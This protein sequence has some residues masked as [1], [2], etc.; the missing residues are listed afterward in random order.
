MQVR[1][2]DDAKLREEEYAN[3]HKFQAV[4]TLSL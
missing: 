4:T 3:W 1:R 2:N